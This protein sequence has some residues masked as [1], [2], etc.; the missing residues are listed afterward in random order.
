MASMLEIYRAVRTTED[1]WLPYTNSN[2]EFISQTSKCL[3]KVRIFFSV[4]FLIMLV[5]PKAITGAS[6]ADTLLREEN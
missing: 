1:T 4:W 5:L 6:K 3:Q 2:A